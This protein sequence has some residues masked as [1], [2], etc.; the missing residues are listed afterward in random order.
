MREVELKGVVDDL[1]KRRSIVESAGGKLVFEGRLIDRRY[2]D[3]S[4][5]MLSRDQVVRLRVYETAN[6]INGSLDWKGPTSYEDGY[7]IRDEVSTKVED[8]DAMAKI[9]ESLGFSEILEIERF[10]A[11]YEL[12]GATVRFE[13]YPR[14]D[15]LVEVEGTPREIEAAI[16]AM[17][18]ARSAFT[19]E[20]LSAFASR[21]EARTGNRAAFTSRELAGNYEFS[22][23]T[24]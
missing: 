24:T 5:R 12:K 22:H 18:M 15:I 8:P 23:D 10:I 11:Q 13:T 7:K 6:G 1:A 16:D 20:R 2:G 19:P 4:G 17:G 21:Y 9:L 3:S 14:M